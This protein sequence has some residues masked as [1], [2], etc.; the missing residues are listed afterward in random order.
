MGVLTTKDWCDHLADV[1]TVFDH[2]IADGHVLQRDLV[3]QR[4]VLHASKG[5]R[6]VQVEYESGQ[7]HSRCHTFDY[8]DRNR[9]VR[10][11]QYTMDH[12]A[13]LKARRSAEAHSCI[14]A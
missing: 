7:G 3:A 14:S 5:Q 8:D 10:I 1:D 4:Y 2:R 12:W 13:L 9:V 11:M 6:P